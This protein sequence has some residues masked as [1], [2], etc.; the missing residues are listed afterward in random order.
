MVLLLVEESLE[1]H[2]VG[3]IEVLRDLQL[4]V[5]VFLVLQNVLN[6]KHTIIWVENLCLVSYYEVDL[7]ESATT[8]E[9]YHCILIELLHCL[10]LLFSVH[11]S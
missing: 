8:N 2:N 10:L 11:P 6:C 7:A 3:M 4:T 5:L 9:L 1:L